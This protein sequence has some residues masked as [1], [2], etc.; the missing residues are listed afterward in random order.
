MELKDKDL[1][2][3]QETRNLLTQ[4]YE[5]SRHL[6]A[7]RQE[8]IDAIVAAISRAGLTHAEKLHWL[9]L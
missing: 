1:M 9:N 6:A 2:S 5:A 4:A 7:L 3:V 8:Q